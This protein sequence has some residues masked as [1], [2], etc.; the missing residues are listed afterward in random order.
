MVSTLAA[1]GIDIFANG[2]RQ[3]V[4]KA[5]NKLLWSH[6][7]VAYC[8]V[9]DVDV[10]LEAGLAS[11]SSSVV[12]RQG[13]NATTTAAAPGGTTTTGG[14]TVAPTTR[15]SSTNGTGGG[16]SGN[17]LG[18]D[19]I[20]A[21]EVFAFQIFFWIAIALFLAFLY[22]ANSIASI[23]IPADSPLLRNLPDIYRPQGQVMRELM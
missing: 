15:P 6:E 14:A 9:A 8:P 2:N 5:L 7:V 10:S 13:P 4:C 17:D 12:A 18:D 22:A 3:E 1:F 19:A 11:S 20:T 23:D 21:A 16:G